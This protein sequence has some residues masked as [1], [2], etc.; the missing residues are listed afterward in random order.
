MKHLRI[1]EYLVKPHLAN[2]C[3]SDEIAVASDGL[4]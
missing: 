1:A 4:L 3:R 2:F